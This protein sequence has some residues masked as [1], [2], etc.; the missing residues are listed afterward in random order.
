MRPKNIVI[1]SITLGVFLMLLTGLI[2]FKAGLWHSNTTIAVDQNEFT[3][4]SG[5][6]SLKPKQV[7]IEIDSGKIEN[8]T[9]ALHYTNS[10]SIQ[11]TIRFDYQSYAASSKSFI[12][13]K[14]DDMER[15]GLP[16]PLIPNRPFIIADTFSFAKPIR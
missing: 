13:F 5:N 9:A 16:N 7:S 11:P 1:E 4:K 3:L 10:E 6:S 2:I 15:H 8:N 14:P 12:V